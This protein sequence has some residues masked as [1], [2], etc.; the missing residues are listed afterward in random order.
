MSGGTWNYRQFDIED[1]GQMV[2]HFTEAIARSEH[3]CDWAEACDT[4][5]ERAEHDLYDLWV[6]TFDKVFGR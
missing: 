1:A 2:A 6:A 5:R 4:S 3:I